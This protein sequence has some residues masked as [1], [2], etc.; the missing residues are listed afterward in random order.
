MFP[1]CIQIIAFMLRR[2]LRGGAQLLS[3]WVG[4][5]LFKEVVALLEKV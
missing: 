2:K 4:G 1:L 3:H 5:L